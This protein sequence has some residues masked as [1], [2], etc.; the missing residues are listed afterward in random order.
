MAKPDIFTM[1]KFE[2]EAREADDNTEM[3]YIF[4]L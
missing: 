1:I 4:L 2:K 3:N